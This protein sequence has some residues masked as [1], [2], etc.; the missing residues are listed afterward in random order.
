VKLGAFAA[1]R[2]VSIHQQKEFRV[3]IAAPLHFFGRHAETI[4][5]NGYSVVAVLPGT[6]R[7]R[8]PNWTTAC[9]KDSDP[10]F[11]ARHAAKF[12]H[13][14]IGIA[15]G[16][17][18]V[19]IDIDETD[20]EQAARFHRI[21][22]EVFGD[23]PLVRVG[24]LP[25]RLLV[26]RAREPIHTMRCGVEV[27][28]CGSNFVAFGI[29]PVTERPY[30]WPQDNPTDTDIGALPAVDRSLIERLLQRVSAKPVVVIVPNNDNTKSRPRA[31]PKKE[32]GGL[33]S[34]IVRNENGRVVEGREAFMTLLVC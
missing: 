2:L 8:F 16:T 21:A 15:C 3:S 13:D 1:P 20:T 25:K 5:D 4:V 12:P 32:L 31:L 26:Y 6:K 14:S 7:P 10:K 23:T 33:Q 24:Q 30:Y 28:G 17:K 27:L 34:R 9:F 18:V 19:G 11:V 29:H 22:L